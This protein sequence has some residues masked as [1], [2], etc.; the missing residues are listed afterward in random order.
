MIFLSVRTAEPEM[1]LETV[2][3]H[4]LTRFTYKCP[5]TGSTKP[6]IRQF[7]LG[8]LLVIHDLL[9]FFYWGFRVLIIP[10]WPIKASGH[11]PRFV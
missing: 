2:R 11:I 5:T 6:K 1:R 10:N 8:D 9:M 3:V 4:S 7:P